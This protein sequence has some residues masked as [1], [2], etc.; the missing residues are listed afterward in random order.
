MAKNF[1]KRYIWLIDLINRRK[2]VS[3]KEI[4]EAWRRSPLN[5]TGEPLSERTFFNHKDAIFITRSLYFKVELLL[6][7]IYLFLFI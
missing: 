4:S 7:F 1:F 6:F 2:Y 3:F 5:E